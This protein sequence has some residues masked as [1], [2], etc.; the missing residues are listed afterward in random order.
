MAELVGAASHRCGSGRT[1]LRSE[2]LRSTVR[3]AIIGGVRDA[4]RD[5]GMPRPRI[6]PSTLSSRD[7]KPLRPPRPVRW[8]KSYSGQ[9]PDPEQTRDKNF[10]K[11]SLYVQGN[12]LMVDHRLPRT[13]TWHR[14]RIRGKPIVLAAAFLVRAAPKPN[15]Q[16]RVIPR[17]DNKTHLMARGGFPGRRAAPLR[18]AVPSIK[19]RNAPGKPPSGPPKAGLPR[20]QGSSLAAQFALLGAA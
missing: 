11:S 9:G 4:P 13:D 5:H 6:E 7:R 2:R 19:R 3:C 17:V 20:D 14:R 18:D 15:V 12:M 10:G 8:R 16:R 1:S